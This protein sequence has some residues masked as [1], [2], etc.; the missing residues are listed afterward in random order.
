MVFGRYSISWG[1][2]WYSPIG[3]VK[4][5]CSRDVVSPSS[6]MATGTLTDTARSK[7]RVHSND[8]TCIKK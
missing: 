5:Y 3:P 8:S 7:E 6:L 1:C 4:G 2:V